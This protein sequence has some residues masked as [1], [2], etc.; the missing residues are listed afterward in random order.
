[1]N[2]ITK[3]LLVTGVLTL[4]VVAGCSN[5]PLSDVDS[6]KGGPVPMAAKPTTPV[7]NTIS[8]SGQL[9]NVTFDGTNTTFTY[10]FISN[11]DGGPAI[12]HIVLELPAE[13]G[14]GVLVSSSDPLAVWSNP[15][16]TTGVTGVKFDTGYND[17]ETRTVTVTLAGAFEVGPIDIAVKS[18]NGFKM[19]TIEGPAAQAVATKIDLSGTVF[20]DING[21]GVKEIDEPAIPGVTVSISDIGQVVTDGAGG[22]L[23]EVDPGTYTVAVALPGGF[24]PTTPASVTVTAATSDITV[25]FGAALDFGYIAGKSAN[26]YTIGFWKTN[27]DKALDGKTKGIQV[28]KATLETYLAGING[29]ALAPFAT[30]SLAGASADLSATGSNPV[31]LLKK[32]LLAAEFNYQSGANIGGDRLFTTLFVYYGEYLIVHSAEFSAETLLRA[33]DMYDTYNNSHGL[34]MVW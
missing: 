13:W 2:A 31:T 12:S 25:N 20:Y 32:Q 5:N 10:T 1:M 18:G 8:Y 34:P 9:V 22:Y 17:G 28:T 30:T 14:P 4:L 3:K 19:G 16:P 33:K 29:F 15:D 6:P 7:N 21:N 27:I 23:V 11:P 24:N 26:G